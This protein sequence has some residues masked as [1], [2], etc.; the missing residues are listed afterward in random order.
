M[1][2]TCSHACAGDTTR[3]M[4]GWS[5]GLAV[6]LLAFLLLMVG[7]RTADAA[8]TAI[9]LATLAPETDIAERFSVRDDGE[10]TDIT[11]PEKALQASGW[12]EGEAARQRLT[13]PRRESTVWLEASV[14]NSSDTPLKRWIQLA[15]WRLVRVDAW[16]MAPD[17][18][19]VLSHAQAGR[20]LAVEERTVEEN[21]VLLPITLA[22]GERQRVLIRVYSTSRPFLSLNVRDPVEFTADE[23]SQLH[24]HSMLLASILTLLAVLL[25]QGDRRYALIG[26]WMLVTF[27]FESGKEGYISQI[28]PLG[29]TDYAYN[30][31]YTTWPLTSALFLAVSVV[32]LEQYKQRRWR[33]A[34]YAALGA[35]LVFGAST[36]VLDGDDMRNL[37]S[38]IDL[39]I[40]AGW[41]GLVPR[42]LRQTSLWQRAVLAL[43]GLYWAAYSFILLGYVFNFYYT[44]A[45]S[46]L[47]LAVEI[48]TTLGLLLVYARQKRIREQRLEQL[49]RSRESQQR[50]RLKSTVAER[51]RELKQAMN[52][53][54]EANAAKTDFLTRITHD[55]RSP[56][57][58]ILGYSQ[59]LSA[60][61]GKIGTMNRTVHSSAT[62]MLNLVNRLIGYARGDD[63]D[64]HTSDIYLFDFLRSV[65]DDARRTAET[66]GN[67]FHL[68][69]AEGLAPVI[70]T[71]ATWLR[72]IL[73]NLLDNA[74][75]HTRD[76]EITLAVTFADPDTSA[77]HA[78]S[79]DKR[80][81]FCITDTGCGI[82][83]AIQ[84]K[85]WEPFYQAPGQRD[86]TGLGLGLAIS[87]RLTRQ[88]GGQLSLNSTPGQGTRVCVTLPLTPGQ[89]ND[90]QAAIQALP[91]HVLPTL[92]AQGLAVW[93][94]EDAAAIRELLHT[95]L[96]SQGFAPRLFADAEAFIDAAASAASPPDLV[97][98]DHY[99]PG[100]NGDAVLAAS[101]Q[102]WPNTPVVLV[103][104]TP[105][106]DNT[107]TE[108]P[109]AY[110]A[111]FAKPLNLAD[112]RRRLA[113]LCGCP[114]TEAAAGDGAMEKATPP[115]AR[116]ASGFHV[117]AAERDKLEQMVSLGAVTDLTEW[118]EALT[119]REP[120]R[121]ELAATLYDLAS[122]GRFDEI[123]D[124]L[125]G[126]DEMLP[127]SET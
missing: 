105:P 56:L 18:G 94:V 67:R 81:T 123:R 114:L 120:A 64:K 126:A 110:A 88:L 7:G 122:R 97:I 61:S 100:A 4:A 63:G 78:E 127:E 84:E 117:T 85:L 59:L 121:R 77:E 6:L 15:P 104:A 91:H 21:H 106:A 29:L 45:F 124:R 42:A 92:H 14:K 76:G 118:C 27:I 31:R 30:L 111:C 20:G 34:V 96:A 82:P 57:T 83:P 125:D 43:L 12:V 112:L 37:G 35:T 41:L 5:E 95:E 69:T 22:A 47:K 26:V 71:D 113:G 65:A 40:A 24:G 79:A 103:S 58:T 23:A 33:L 52:E 80:L 62:H 11:A 32:L 90:A 50:E 46:T 66:E 98:T 19:E 54:H 44:A 53:A 73:M 36:F 8:D 10:N 93:V 119:A 116:Q 75:R 70:H 25:L 101:S 99:L 109:E 86:R 55:L 51:T 13:A 38:L 102:R 74:A 49:L 108:S 16:F 3:R 107:P 28:L 2:H 72:Q 17:S 9:D 87:A 48:I 60:E 1:L 115:A 89:E 39:S 68:E